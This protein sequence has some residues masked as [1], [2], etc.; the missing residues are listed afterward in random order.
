MDRKR[1]NMSAAGRHKTRR[2]EAQ[3]RIPTLSSSTNDSLAIV[4]GDGE[5]VISA[6]SNLCAGTLSVDDSAPERLAIP[7]GGCPVDP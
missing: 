2:E 3:P 5:W 1:D 4:S 7:R 6:F